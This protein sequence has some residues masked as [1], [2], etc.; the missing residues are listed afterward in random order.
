MIATIERILLL[1][2][3]NL[4][5]IIP[6]FLVVTVT[7]GFFLML[8]LLAYR[9]VPKESHDILLALIA[10][11]Q[12]A[13]VGIVAYHFG[14]SAGSAAKTAIMAQQNSTTSNVTLPE[15]PKP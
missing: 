14:S 1:I 10:S 5:K 3:D 8:V 4:G 9:N 6:A 15:T 12:T 2:L 7:N 13:W 11:L